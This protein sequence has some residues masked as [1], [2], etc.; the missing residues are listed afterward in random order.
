MDYLRSGRGATF[1]APFSTRARVGATVATPIDWE[2]LPRVPTQ[3]FDIFIVPERLR[4]LRKDP[5]RGLSEI[6]QSLRAS[7]LRSVASAA[8][9]A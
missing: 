1:I 9:K 8:R 2:E 4:R 7:Q 6:K 5:W 3:T